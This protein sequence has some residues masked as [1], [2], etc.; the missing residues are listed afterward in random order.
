MIQSCLKHKPPAKN[1]NETQ[2][3]RSFTKLIFEGNTRAASQLLLGHDCSKILN[4]ND[5]ADPSNPRYL[6]SDALR[7]KHQPAQ[8]LQ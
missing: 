7:D 4:L 2:V 3:T 8:P 1:S 5:S 6:V